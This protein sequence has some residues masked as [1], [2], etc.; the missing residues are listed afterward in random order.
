MQLNIINNNKDFLLPEFFSLKLNKI[1][2]G[3]F[4]PSRLLSGTN[5]SR[6]K[7]KNYW[8]L[9]FW[10]MRIPKV[11]VVQ[12][13]SEEIIISELLIKVEMNPEVVL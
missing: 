9:I 3:Y 5:Y 12:I 6:R 10:V 1:F 8:N 4:R 13:M 11:R 2:L 7:K